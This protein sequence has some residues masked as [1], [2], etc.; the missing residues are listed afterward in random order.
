MKIKHA[1]EFLQGCSQLLFESVRWQVWGWTRTMSG[2]EA[3]WHVFFCG[4]EH[5]CLL[6]SSKDKIFKDLPAGRCL[7]CHTWEVD[8]HEPSPGSHTHQPHS[9]WGHHQTPRASASSPV[10]EEQWWWVL[11]EKM[12][13]TCWE[14]S[15]AHRTCSIMLALLTDTLNM[16]DYSHP[17]P[18]F[19]L[20][21]AGLLVL[22]EQGPQLIPLWIHS[23]EHTTFNWCVLNWRKGIELENCSKK[24]KLM[25]T[26]KQGTKMSN[27]HYRV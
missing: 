8:M 10:M 18:I 9:P 19:A 21:L 16:L 20:N 7:Q 22:E 23:P 12:Q 27:F 2:K 14:E 26:T 24:S 3:A 25:N 13:G 15:L 5:C 6:G 4:A 1:F 11:N 17:S